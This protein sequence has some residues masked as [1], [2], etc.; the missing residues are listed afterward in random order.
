MFMDKIKVSVVMPVYNAHEY[1]DNTL[2]DVT[3]QTLKE[4]EIICVDDGSTDDS[5]EIIQR[6]Q[7]MDSR[8]KLI[9]QKNQYAGVARNNGLTHAVGKYVVF[10]DSD[11]IFYPEALEKLYLQSEEQQTDICVCAATRYDV[12]RDCYIES[13]AYLDERY[14]PEGEII[15]NKWNNPGGI[16]DF[17]TNNP[18]NKMYRREFILEKGLQYQNLRQANDTYFTMMALYHAERISY[19]KEILIAYR[20]N[21]SGSLTGKASDTALCVYEAYRKTK[22]EL[23]RQ[24]EFELVKN[25]F[26]SHCLMGFLMGLNQQKNF[27]SYARL[28]NKLVNEGF[29]EIGLLTC[30]K[31][32]IHVGWQYD[33]M[34]TMLQ[35]PAED[36]LLMKSEAR[37]QSVTLWKQKKQKGDQKIRVLRSK[38]EKI[39]EDKAK[40]LEKLEKKHEKEIR[41]IQKEHDKQMEKLRKENSQQLQKMK[42]ENEAKM[43]KLRESWDYRIGRKICGCLRKIKR[44][45]VRKR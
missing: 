17:A 44:I 2:H 39:R 37:R 12:K 18:W 25:S 33:D 5:V 41:K 40:A 35:M 27:E 38:V 7:T 6:W 34:M 42:Q 28:Y 11:D 31:E 23:A 16:F 8:I 26:Y 21:N 10:W 30:A 45:F 14:M 4:I 29:E 43:K 32:D 22:E 19:V 13:A 20:V 24:S 1:L 15:I 36:F 9:T 3:E